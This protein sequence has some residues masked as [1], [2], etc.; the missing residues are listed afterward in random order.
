[1]F[2]CV[3]YLISLRYNCYGRGV[4]VVK[5][6]IT[7]ST[8]PRIGYPVRSNNNAAAGAVYM[9]PEYRLD[10]LKQQANKEERV[11]AAGVYLVYQ[12]QNI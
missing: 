2:I 8:A 7:A 10:T 5:A 11:R 9:W 6:G 12:K 1:M 3:R 4:C